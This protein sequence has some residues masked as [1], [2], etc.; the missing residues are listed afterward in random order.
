MRNKPTRHAPTLTPSECP[1][2]RRAVVPA[3]PRPT[4]TMDA[5]KIPLVD[6]ALELGVSYQH[7]HRLMLTKR[8]DG[9]RKGRGWQVTRESVDAYK[10]RTGHAAPTAPQAA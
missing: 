1:A 6:A 4:P 7:A 5:A 8:L 9:E 3:P 10:R 2:T